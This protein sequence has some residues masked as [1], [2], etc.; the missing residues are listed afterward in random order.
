[1]DEPNNQTT[2]TSPSLNQGFHSWRLLGIVLA[3]VVLVCLVFLHRS[4]PK[5]EAAVISSQVSINSSSF[6]PKTIQVSTGSTVTWTNYDA[7]S[8]WV[9]ADPYPSNGS[10]PG[11]SSDA[12]AT[13][14][15]Y[16]Y[17]FEKPGTY[18]YHDELNPLKLMG[19]VVVK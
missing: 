6:F 13:Q 3:V 16:S 9:A 5:V 11:L 10:Q 2:Q 19:S 4:K 7:K 8:H 17:T 1:M 15:S 18:T 14:D 12:L